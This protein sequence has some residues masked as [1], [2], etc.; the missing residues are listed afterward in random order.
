AMGFAYYLESLEAALTAEGLDG[1][2]AGD[3]AAD[4]LLVPSGDGYSRA[5]QAAAALRESGFRVVV[6]TEERPLMATRRH[7]EASGVRWVVV[8][9]ETGEVVEEYAAGRPDRFGAARSP[10]AV[11]G[12]APR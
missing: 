9:S 4:V 12:D 8:L 6:G 5:V 2:S 10:R 11:L 3:G 1:P 7:A